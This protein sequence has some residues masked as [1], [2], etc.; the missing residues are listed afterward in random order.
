M[1]RALG[2]ALMVAMVAFAGCQDTEPSRT[3]VSLQIDSD[4][5]DTWIYL[6]TIPRVKMGN[7]SLDV[8]G[9]KDT[10]SSV[11]SHQIHINSTEMDILTKDTE[12]FFTFSAEADLSNVFWAFACK[13]RISESFENSKESVAADVLIDVNDEEIA[14]VWELP[15]NMHL[16]FKV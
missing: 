13:L 15:H 4:G 3:I 6:Y 5:E 10:L 16:E 11:F 7:L 8:A 9:N 14:K 2:M 12:G 1:Y